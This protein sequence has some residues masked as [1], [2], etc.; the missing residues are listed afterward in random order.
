[1]D[2]QRNH[3]LEKDAGRNFFKHVK[4]F[5]SFEKPKALD[6]RRLLPGQDDKSLAE[7]LAAYFNQDPPIA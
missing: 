6:F 2:T 5:A 3:Q 7:F 4:S 1:M